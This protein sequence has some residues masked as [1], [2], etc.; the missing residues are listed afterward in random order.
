MQAVALGIYVTA[1]THNPLWTGLVAAAAFLPVGLLSPVGGAL[2]DRL[3]R[4]RWLIVTT[5]AEMGMATLLTVLAASGKV[6]PVTAV[7]VAFFGGAA[8]AIGFPSYQAMLPD[9]VE[10]R[11]DLLAAVALSSAQFNLGRVIGPVLAG[12][13]LTL[14]HYAFAFGCNAVS[15]AAVVGAL[16]FVH[17]PAPEPVTEPPRILRRIA[18]GARIAAGEPGCRSAIILIGVVALLAS[19]FI[20]L[21]PAMAIDALHLGSGH[22]GSFGTAV[23]VTAQGLGAVAGALILPGMAVRVGRRRQVV[24]AL[25]ILPP[26]LVAYAVAPSLWWSAVALLLVGACYIGVLSGLNTV[27]QL[28]APHAARGRVLSLYML[29]LGTIYPIGAILQGSVGHVV[30]VREVTAAGAIV[31]AVVLAGVLVFRPSAFRA[32]DATEAAATGVAEQPAT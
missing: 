5:F 13:A 12:V 24:G 21:V 23:L 1:T 20:A 18:E 2:A 19:P 16:F 22:K 31:L 9:L 26:L 7:V 8:G 15:F 27:V 3:D 32:L 11:D 30:G 25:F 10:D 4:R 29:S 28:R 17:L 6:T 14:G